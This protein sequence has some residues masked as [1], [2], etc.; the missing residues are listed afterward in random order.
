MIMAAMAHTEAQ[1]ASGTLPVVHITTEDSIKSKTEYVE[2]KLYID[3]VVAEDYAAVASA[4]SPMLIG[5]RGRGNWTWTGNFEKKAYKIKLAQKTPLLGMAAN[6]H[7]A[8]LAHADGSNPFLRNAAAFHT[9]IMLRLDFTPAERPVELYLNGEYRGLYFL[10]ETV[11]L[12]SNRVDITEQSDMETDDEAITGGWLIELDNNNDSQQLKFST[13]GTDLGWLWVTYHSP[14]VLSSEQRDYLRSQINTLVQ[15]IYTDDKSS[16]EW[17][18]MIDVE[19]LARYYMTCEILDHTEGF[20][21][22]CYLYKDRGEQRWKFGPVW[23]FGNAFNSGHKKDEFCYNY[24]NGW[25][26]GLINEIVKF[27]RFQQQVRRVWDEFYPSMY[28]GLRH[29]LTWYAQYIHDAAECDR[30]RWGYA[31]GIDRQLEKCLNYLE[32]KKDFLMSQ[33]NDSKIMEYQNSVKETI[34][35]EAEEQIYNISGQR[36]NVTP[37]RGVYI[38]GKKKYIK[39]K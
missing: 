37:R 38:K 6:K 1:T 19:S 31:D 3:N 34:A 24:T 22:S 12:G 18:E 20:L 25:Y 14:E 16:T 29:Y 7:F 11:R 39:V 17:E 36:M 21:G 33:W 13:K 8:L 23:D 15:R 2:G 9:S 4:E 30:Q 10:T 32:Q 27:P 26:P 35:E 28:D 5:I